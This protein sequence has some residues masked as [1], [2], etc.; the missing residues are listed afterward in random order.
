MSSYHFKPGESL[1]RMEPKTLGLSY[2]SLQ[3]I[4]FGKKEQRK[5]SSG[6][7]EICLAVIN[8]NLQFEAAGK[9]GTAETLDMLYLPC[10]SE[11]CISSDNAVVIRYGAPCSR[12]TSFAH[13]TFREVDADSRHKTYGKQET[14]TKRD[15]WNYIDENFDSS[16]FLIGMCKGAPGGWTAWPPHEHG[17]KRE[18]VYVYFGMGEG[19]GIQ[20][21]YNDLEGDGSAMIVRDGHI[22]SIPQGYHP[23]AGSPHCGLQYIYCMVSLTAEDRSF[24]DLTIQKSFGTVFE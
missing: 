12:K 22:V 20:C 17:S 13:I 1:G 11:I 10:E 23:N 21:V 16:R 9:T 18:E 4:E 24:M 7:E 6:K 15:V 8:G 14:G 2:T 5:I 3:R 19:F